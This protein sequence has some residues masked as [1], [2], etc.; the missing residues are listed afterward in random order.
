MKNITKILLLCFAVTSGV[1]LFQ[2]QDFI[3]RNYDDNNPNIDQP[4]W[5]YMSHHKA[6]E[7]DGSLDIITD[8]DGFDE[9]APD[10]C[11]RK[12]QSSKC[13]KYYGWRLNLD[14]ESTELPSLH[15]L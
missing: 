12:W 4:T 1:M 8:A 13:Q 11:R 10:I 5:E 2:A 3:G 14:I 6:F 7:P 9:S 15:M